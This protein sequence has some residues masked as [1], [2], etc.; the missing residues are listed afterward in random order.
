MKGSTTA[1]LVLLLR[2]LLF[3]PPAFSQISSEHAQAI[4][5]LASSYVAENHVP[6]MAIAV[7]DQGQAVFSQG[8][9]LADVEN[10]VPAT[11]E[12]VFRV[13][14]LSKPISATAAMKLVEAGKLNLD[15][16]VQKY[17]PV[18]PQKAWPLT[19]R[20]VL[21]HQ[22]GIRDYRDEEETINT[23]HYVS[24]RDALGQ[25]AGDPLDF[26]PGTKMHYTSYGY[27]VLGCVIE[28]ASGMSYAD[29]MGQ[30]IFRPANMPATRLDDVFAMIPHRARGYKISNGKLQNATFVDV[31]N[32]PP[33]SGVNSDAR[34]M[35]NFVAALYA[36]TLVSSDTLRGMLTA[37]KTAD[38]KPTICGLGFFVGGPI[39]TYHGLQ[40]AGHGGD[41]QGVSSVLYLLPEKRFGVVVLSNLEGQESSLHFIDLSRKI[42]D[43]V[44]SQ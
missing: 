1:A 4:D 31:S 38:G 29:Y 40:E 32:K 9:G 42:Y 22:S 28:G 6:G 19:T 14:S 25:F 43:I 13:A 21:S 20:Q 24:I 10:N 41:Q 27:V 39:G 30:A 36:D 37:E 23:R 3:T 44:S 26:E 2:I 16:P 35:G 33:G 7:V 17:C 5:R 34:D 8:Y 12:T 11:A 18:F 15:A